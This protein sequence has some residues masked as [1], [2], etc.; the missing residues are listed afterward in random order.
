MPTGTESVCLRLVLFE[1]CLVVG[2]IL[3]YSYWL[4]VWYPLFS[5]PSDGVFGRFGLAALLRLPHLK[6]LVVCFAC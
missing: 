2:C 5:D 4:V 3:G 6:F 1:I